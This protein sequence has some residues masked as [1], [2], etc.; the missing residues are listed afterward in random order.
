MNKKNS[1]LLIIALIFL[2]PIVFYI[3]K[4]GSVHK[5]SAVSAV[6]KPLIIDFYSDLCLECRDLEKVLIP[7][8]HKYQG[9]VNIL[10]VSIADGS[11]ESQKLIN[12]YK[13]KVVPTVVVLDNAGKDNIVYRDTPDKIT[14]EKKI[15]ELIKHE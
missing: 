8:K 12:K 15:N 5:S 6:G 7:L 14:L 2:L 4:Q 9:K 13:V 11:E 1:T 10:R 3:V